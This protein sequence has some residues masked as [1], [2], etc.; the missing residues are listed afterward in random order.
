MFSTQSVNGL[1][2]IGFEYV[3]AMTNLKL[4]DSLAF[5]MFGDDAQLSFKIEGKNVKKSKYYDT[6]T[7]NEFVIDFRKGIDSP[8]A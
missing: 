3:L 5:K 6:G 8:E 7:S 1:S 2:G 4:F